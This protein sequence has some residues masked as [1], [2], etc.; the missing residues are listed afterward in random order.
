MIK[1]KLLNVALQSASSSLRTTTKFTN[2]F[3]FISTLLG[4]SLNHRVP[5]F[6]CI[7]LAYMFLLLISH[8]DCEIHRQINSQNNS[9]C[10]NNPRDINE[11][12][13]EINSHENDADELTNLLLHL[14]KHFVHFNSRLYFQI[15]NCHYVQKFMKR[16]VNVYRQ[17]PLTRFLPGLNFLSGGS[18]LVGARQAQFET[19]AHSSAAVIDNNLGGKHANM[20]GQDEISKAQANAAQANDDAPATIFDK[21]LA[22]EIPSTEVFS[23][24]LCYAFR[25]ISPQAKVH[26]LVIPKVRDGLTMLEKAREDQEELLG[27]LLK[28]R[29]NN[30]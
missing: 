17:A 1:R 13:S 9:Y 21:I 19:K 8:R 23:D 24:D 15:A 4:R 25:D 2:A 14:R 10:P 27:H 6:I 16:L 3:Y 11:N 7:M 22:K 5:I 26:F 29:E 18:F 20:A 28:V 30:I 12:N